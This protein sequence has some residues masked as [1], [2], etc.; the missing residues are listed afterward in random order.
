W[1]L[2]EKQH[3]RKHALWEDTTRTTLIFSTPKT[4]ASS[5]PA[6]RDCPRVVSLIDLYPTISDLCGIKT[7]ENLDGQSIA[8]LLKDPTQTWDRP[9][10]MTF[11][12]GNHA[13]RTEH[14]RFIRY[15]DGGEELY[16][17][18]IDPNEWNN[19]AKQNHEA[20][21]SSM[22]TKLAEMLK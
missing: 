7:P 21:L 22:R 20:T 17:H 11:G 5:S 15:K 2:G 16:D 4:R 3:W 18:R 1:H 10:L 14:W 12:E 13:L 19:L 8:P 6:P 9:A